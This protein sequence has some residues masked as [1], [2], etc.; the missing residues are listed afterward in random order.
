M[1]GVACLSKRIKPN[2]IPR[3]F[4]AVHRLSV[5]LGFAGLTGFP[6]LWGF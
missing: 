5:L 1:R 2:Q 3:P 4:T 6:C